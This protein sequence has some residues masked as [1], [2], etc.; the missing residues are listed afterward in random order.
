MNYRA[1]FIAAALVAS[2][3]GESGLS[4]T[5]LSAGAQTERITIPRGPM[6]DQTVRSRMTQGMTLTIDP[7][8]AGAAMPQMTLGM[9]MVFAQ[10][11]KIGTPDASKHYQATMTVDQASADMTMNGAAMPMPGGM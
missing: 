6:P 8:D 4:R 3:H 5:L 11:M 10:T 1:A 9:K 2:F 7:S